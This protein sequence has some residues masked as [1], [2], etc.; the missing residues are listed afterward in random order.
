MF[1][2]RKEQHRT[3]LQTLGFVCIQFKSR[4]SPAASRGQM[5]AV[6]WLPRSSCSPGVCLKVSTEF[7]DNFHNIGRNRHLN[8]ISA[9]KVDFYPLKI[10]NRTGYFKNLCYLGQAVARLGE[11]DGRGQQQRGRQRHRHG[12][13]QLRGGRGGGGGGARAEAGRHPVRGRGVLAAAA[14]AGPLCAVQLLL[15][16]ELDHGGEVAVQVVHLVTA[17]GT[18]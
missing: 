8:I 5:A 6:I 12:A 9:P 11:R 15:R 3:E 16:H 14:V 7:C 4:M 17:G 2:V 18:R 10:F 13:R 1:Y